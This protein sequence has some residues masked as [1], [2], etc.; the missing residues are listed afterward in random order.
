MRT[1]LKQKNLDVIIFKTWYKAEAVP[2]KS[3]E[4]FSYKISVKETE[5]RTVKLVPFILIMIKAH[6]CSLRFEERHS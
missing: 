4:L 3:E 1:L 2:V 5:G 6:D